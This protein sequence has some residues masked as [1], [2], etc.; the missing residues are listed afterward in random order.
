VSGRDFCNQRSW[1][2]KEDQE[3]MI[4]NHSVIHPKCP[5]KKGFVRA[6]SI[7][8]G[9]LMRVNPDGKSCT[10]IYITHTD[11]KGSIPSFVMNFMTKTFA[12]K[13]IGK[14]EAAGKEYPNWK[15]KHAPGVYL[16]RGVGGL[17]PLGLAP[18]Y[19]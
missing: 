17:L 15:A 19:A 3:Y 2:V 14:L 1:R 18:G 6:N 10:L 4:I 8:S 16:W 7:N 13:I 5:E 11:P 9:Y 12:P